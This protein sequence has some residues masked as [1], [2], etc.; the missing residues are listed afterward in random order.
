LDKARIWKLAIGDIL[1]KVNC[2]VLSSFG[3]LESATFVA[4]QLLGG[5]WGIYDRESLLEVLQELLDHG[6][7]E[8]YQQCVEGNARTS[9]E[10]SFI[11]EFEPRLTHCHLRAWDIGR[12]ATLARWG[13]HVGFLTEEEY[14]SILAPAARE[15]QKTY[16]SWSQ[17]GEHYLIGRYFWSQSKQDSPHENAVNFLTQNQNSPWNL[18]EWNADLQISHNPDWQS[19]NPYYFNPPLVY[20]KR[21]KAIDQYYQ[22]L[23]RFD[24][25]DSNLYNAY[26][27]FLEDEFGDTE[28]AAQCFVKSI[29]YSFGEDFPFKNLVQLFR[30]SAKPA[31]QI[32][33]LFKLWMSRVSHSA[34]PYFYYADWLTDIQSDDYSLIDSCYQKAVSLDPENASIY[35]DYG[36]YLHTTMGDYSAARNMYT[37]ALDLEPED[38]VVQENL[39]LLEESAQTIRQLASKKEYAHFF[40][41][42]LM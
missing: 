26:G 33:N 28:R 20:N 21:I 19:G 36:F 10:D 31:K 8:I 34:M 39:A 13:Q 6:D 38:E 3:S 16:S 5:Q 17:F 18:V 42:D 11:R 2:D 23:V 22:L 29:E 9:F 24:S 41:N 14:W 37:K 27:L 4:D 12:Y 35:N 30:R 1:F 40:R 15:L 7:S 25:I 32:H